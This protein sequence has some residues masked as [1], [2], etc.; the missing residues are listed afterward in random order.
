M[1]RIRQH[2]CRGGLATPSNLCP[3]TV[4]LPQVRA[5]G[6]FRG[7]HAGRGSL[8]AM[9]CTSGLQWQEVHVQEM[10]ANERGYQIIWAWV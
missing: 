10:H 2:L 8:L 5:Q 3:G 6:S 4:M 7:E 9:M 1:R